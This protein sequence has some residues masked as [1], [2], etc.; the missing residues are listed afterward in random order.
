MKCAL[1]SCDQEIPERSGGRPRL[2]CSDAH[3]A[4]A[5]KLRHGGND[6]MNAEDALRNAL[7]AIEQTLEQTS[8][9]NS[10]IVASKE[11]AEIAGA[12]ER[13]ETRL[14][15]A[16]ES[17]N[18]L[19]EELVQVK[20][21]FENLENQ[22]SAVIGELESERTLREELQTKLAEQ[23]AEYE[24][25]LQ[26]LR[27]SQQDQI[28]QIT[29]V[30]QSQ[31]IAWFEERKELQAEVRD[32]SQRLGNGEALV[33]GLR[34]Q[35]EQLVSEVANSKEALES[36]HKERSSV[37]KLLHERE[38]ELAACSSVKD[39]QISQIAALSDQLNKE[40]EARSNE[41]KMLTEINLNI[42]GVVKELAPVVREIKIE[43][44]AREELIT[45]V[46]KLLDENG[47]HS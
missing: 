30:F 7:K 39:Q 15:E 36:E 47:Q 16:L 23:T 21:E 24:N 3:R 4:I 45:K 28:E 35:N 27:L 40:H 22:H 9:Q 46:N 8:E 19:N 42:K 37:E 11:R 14:S 41:A 17:N 10:N 33:D 25:S 6:T 26:S 38:R 5:F 1:E 13:S 2:Y 32:L 20:S 31:Q 12:L 44:K 34:K 18:L 29:N 43:R